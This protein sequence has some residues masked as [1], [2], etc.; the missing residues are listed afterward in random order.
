MGVM[1]KMLGLRWGLGLLAIGVF[2]WSAAGVQAQAVVATIPVGAG[3]ARVAAN[4]TTNR[5]YVTNQFSNNVSVIDGA[6][7]AVIGTVAVGTNP[8]GVDVNPVTNRIYVA[9]F[10]TSSSISVID[11]ASNTVIATIPVAAGQP[12]LVAINRTTNRGYATLPNNDRVVVFDLLTNTVIGAPIVV[13]TFP[14]GGG[15]PG[16]QSDL[17]RQSGVEQRLCDRRDVEHRDRHGGNC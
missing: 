5:I 9:N 7:N 4:P 16:K 6:S 14:T 11:G 12:A 3:P 1:S 13:G 10:S 15:E 8:I 17:H 2:L